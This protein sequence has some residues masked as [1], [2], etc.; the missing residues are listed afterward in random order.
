[1]NH[2]PLLVLGALLVAEEGLCEKGAFEQ[3]LEVNLGIKNNPESQGQ[4]QSDSQH[5][6]EGDIKLSEEQ[7]LNNALYGNP[8]GSPGRAATNVDKIKWPNGVIP[9]EFDCSV[10]NMDRA[11]RTTMEAIAEWESKTCLRFVKRTTETEFLWFHRGN[12]CWCEVGKVSG[13]KTWLSIGSGCEY[14]HVMTHEL[15][16][17]IGFWH[18]QS[19]PDRDNYLKINWENILDSMAY[20]FKKKVQG[21]EVIDYGVPY[22]YSSIMHYPWTAFSKNGKMTLEPIRPLNGKMPYIK[23]SD[24][25]ALQARR[26]YNCPSRAKR[27][28]LANAAPERCVDR[29]PKVDCEGWKQAGFCT[30]HS[31]MIYHCKKTC[32]FCS[33][34]S[35]IDLKSECKKWASDGKCSSDKAYMDKNCPHTCNTCKKCSDPSPQICIDRASSADCASWK[36]SGFCSQHSALIYHCKKTCDFCSSDNCVDLKYD[37]KTRADNDECSSDPVKMEMECPHT[38]GYCNECTK[39]KPTNP[40]KPP[41]PTNPPITGI[42]TVPPTLPNRTGSGL[43][44]VD[45]RK[46]CPSWAASGECKTNG[47][48]ESTCRISCKTRCDTYPIKPKGACSEGLGLGWPGNYKLP[49]NAFSASTEYRP[50]DWRATADNARLY[51]EDD[52]DNKRIG[53][54]CAEDRDNQWLQIDLGQTKT[55]RG[56]ATQ[57]RDVFHEHVK[58]YKLAFSNDGSSFQT[59]QENGKEKVFTGNCDHFTPVVN[60]FNPVKTRYVKIIVVD[61]SYPCMRVELYGCD[62]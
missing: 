34:N 49:D 7:R 29:A 41:N 59:Y 4:R 10:A 11:V 5:L 31:S 50:G 24:D 61:A 37:C 13:R 14:K 21:T 28:A 23:L 38:C 42:P 48:T 53:A 8:D 33:S 46:S 16:H 9:Y 19:R 44:C 6:Y 52:Q 1:M 40:P 25:D 56:I 43:M 36:K 47:W 26:M 22:D 30:Q 27:N 39:P 32:E 54:W 18:E 55:V 35:C 57:G 45:K 15:G 51:F 62:A 20:N 12:G 58:E 60:T 2:L 17:A 3:I